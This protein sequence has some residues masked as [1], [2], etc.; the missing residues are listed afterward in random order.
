MVDIYDITDLEML[1]RDC[2]TR[3]G[4]GADVAARVAREVALAEASGHGE[5]GFE[6]LLRDIRLIRYGRLYPDA[7]VTVQRTAATILRVDA[8]H[9]FAC[10]ALD[11]G[12]SAL[13]ETTRS[14]GM[15]MI[16]LTRASDPGAMVASLSDLARQG[17][18]GLGT[19]GS[20]QVYAIRPDTTHAVAIGGGA[21]TMLQALLSVAPEA[22]DSPLD[23]PVNHS[24]WLAALDPAASAAADMMARLPASTAPEVSRRI[25]VAPDLLAQIVT[26]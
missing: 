4:I 1:A 18:A 20:G 24:A 12:L 8:G 6:A 5:C 19:H 21:Q 16:H 26:A 9:G 22:A 11:S 14:N 7:E 23:G 17:L 25:A 2:L 3:A 15:A 10:C 13:A